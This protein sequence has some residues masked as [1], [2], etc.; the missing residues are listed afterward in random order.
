M[1]DNAIFAMA[2]VWERWKDPSGKHLESCSVLTTSA[3]AL[4]QDIHHRMPVILKPEDYDRWLDPGITDPNQ[5]ADLLQPLDARL[6][7]TYPV[8][9]RVNS[10][11]NDDPS[12]AEPVIISHTAS[13]F[14]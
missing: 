2:G 8:S 10:V 14:G 6:M 1:Q 3:N 13:L 5:M 11:K 9:T 4:L 7:R 12:C